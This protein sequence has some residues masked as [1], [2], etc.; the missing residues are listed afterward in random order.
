MER[1]F[2]KK[3]QNSTTSSALPLHLK[4]NIVVTNRIL[5]ES[6]LDQ[7]ENVNQH[8]L[9]TR[10]ASLSLRW[11]RTRSSELHLQDWHCF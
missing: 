7:E 2:L 9:K 3:G 10:P 5:A 6:L 11:T 8:L 4:K 1:Q